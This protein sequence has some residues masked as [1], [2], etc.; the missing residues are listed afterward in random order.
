MG[1]ILHVRGD[2]IETHHYDH[3]SGKSF[4][5]TS[6][7]VKPYLESNKAK[8]KAARKDWKGPIHH[9][10]SVPESIVI[11]WCAELGDNCLK[12]EHRAWFMAKIKDRDYSKLRVKE[13]NL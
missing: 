8:I 7:D 1:K 4:L 5:Q 11:K 2:I 13:G 10:A 9:V 3:A 6:Q 12:P